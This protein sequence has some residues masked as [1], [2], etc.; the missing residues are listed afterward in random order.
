[1]AM[2]S[3]HFRYR[4]TSWHNHPFFE[5]GFVLAGTCTWHVGSRRKIKL[6]TGDAILLP[7]RRNHYESIGLGVDVS[8]AWL[9][10]DFSGPAP[11]WTESVVALGDDAPEVRFY[12]EAI[13]RE[14]HQTDART[15]SRLRLALQSVLLLLDRRA[16]DSQRQA[17]SKSGLNPRQTHTVESAAHYFRHDLQNPL[18]IAQVAS[19]HS[20]CPAHF[21]SLFR[22]H[23]RITPRGYLRRAR[24]QRAADLLAESEL[25]LKEIAA[26]CGFVD[27]AHL[28][29]AFKEERRVTP[30]FF[31]RQR[32]REAL[33]RIPLD[34][35]LKA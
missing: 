19:Y 17:A 31:R 21:S 6:V 4:R 24:L 5:V 32:R 26:Q 34:D 14:H 8:V 10:F 13:A 28:C 23:H 20:L 7:P 2:L 16:E 1:M 11:G 29:K 25:T 18:S 27:P 22:R 9:G 15:Q 12:I 33:R 3:P 30:G 35:K